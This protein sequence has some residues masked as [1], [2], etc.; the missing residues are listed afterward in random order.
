MKSKNILA[1]LKENK[2]NKDLPED[3]LNLIKKLIH[4]KQHQEKN[5]QDMTAKRGFQ[6][7]S[8]KIR[9]LIKYYQT[10]KVLPA[11]WKLDMD[12]LKMYLE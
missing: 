1:I 8:S 5:R 3:L 10:N 11:D 12:R 6:L 9:R 4:V 2:L 7:T